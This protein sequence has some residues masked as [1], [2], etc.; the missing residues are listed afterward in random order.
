ME[1]IGK[2]KITGEL[3]KGA[4]G[5]VYKGVDPDINRE[6]AIKV[7]RFDMVSDDSD[8]EEAAKR[9]IREAQSAGNLAHPNIMKWEKRTTRHI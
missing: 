3:G 1:Q 4:M 2:Y 9:F 6:V 5:I 8:K 7:I